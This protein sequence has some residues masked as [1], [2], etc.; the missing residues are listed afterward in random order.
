MV[1]LGILDLEM[2][3]NVLL[4][5]DSGRPLLVRQVGD[6][7]GDH[8]RERRMTHRLLLRRGIRLRRFGHLE[9]LRRAR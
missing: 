5:G 6:G 9:F 7:R 4:D 2:G 1:R 3:E 8:L